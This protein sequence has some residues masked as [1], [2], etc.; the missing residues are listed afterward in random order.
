MGPTWV[1]GLSLGRQILPLSLN[2]LDSLRLSDVALAEQASDN[3]VTNTFLI[4]AVKTLKIYTSL[5]SHRAHSPYPSQHL[6]KINA[7]LSPL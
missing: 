3:N 4:F 2:H 6:R 7:A 5:F 1:I